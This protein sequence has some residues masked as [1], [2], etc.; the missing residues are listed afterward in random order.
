M[1]LPKSFMTKLVR[2]GSDIELTMLCRCDFKKSL[3]FA[4][5]YAFQMI[6]W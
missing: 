5:G 6:C 1:K 4:N 2:I 3:I